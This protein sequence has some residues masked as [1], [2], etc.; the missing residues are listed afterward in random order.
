MAH[1]HLG[2]SPNPFTTNVDRWGGSAIV[3]QDSAA[4]ETPTGIASNSELERYVVVQSAAP[5]PPEECEELGRSAIEVTVLW[6]TNVLHVSHLS[7]PRAFTVGHGDGA[8]VDFIVPVELAPFSQS[9]LVA[10]RDGVPYVVAPAGAELRVAKGAPS[11]GADDAHG[12]RTA[13]L[14]DGVVAD[15]SFGALSFR[16]ASVTA[17]KRLP[18]QI[19]GD[20]RG[21]GSSFVATFAAVATLLGSLAYYTPAL[22]STL[23]E[24]LDKERLQ[25]MLAILQANAEREETV[26]PSDG[27][28]QSTDGGGTPGT[29]AKGQEGKMGRPDKPSVQKKFA[30]QGDGEVVLSRE[31]LIAQAKDFGTIGLLNTLNSRAVPQALWGAA[32]PNGPDAQDAWG[33]MFGEDIGES[34][35]VGGLGL[36]GLERGGGGYGEQIGIGGIGTCG[37]N[38]GSGPGKSGFGRGVGGTGGGHKTGVPRVRYAGPVTVSGRIPPEVIQRVVRQNYGRFRSCYEMGLRTNPNLTG[39]VTARFVIGRDGAVTNASNGGG[40]LPDS[41]V[42]SCVVSAFYG[43]SFPAPEGGIVTVSYPIMLVPG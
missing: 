34:G 12:N 3:F 32:V 1:E 33:E 16:I 23:D 39:R 14:A 9:E 30:I 11:I 7:P 10:V 19:G 21:L 15:V 26:K 29:A 20:T 2:V 8:P 41:A 4:E 38:C 35:G 5:V 6:G 18:R 37:T 25:A 28:A 42:T 27:A 36:H 17:G 24:G 43:L 22:G 31:Q 13:M 40:D